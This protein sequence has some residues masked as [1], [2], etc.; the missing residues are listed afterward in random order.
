MMGEFIDDMK[1]AGVKPRVNGVY[2]K[3]RDYTSCSME[4]VYLRFPL[5][6][7]R[8]LELYPRVL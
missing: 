5:V 4:C 6:Y 1:V 2:T 7:P 3:S 8:V